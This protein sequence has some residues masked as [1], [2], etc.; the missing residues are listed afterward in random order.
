MCFETGC[1]LGDLEEIGIRVE[2]TRVWRDPDYP[3][4]QH[5]NVKDV[6]HDLARGAW[7]R[8]GAAYMR[9]RP[10][11]SPFLNGEPWALETFG[12]PPGWTA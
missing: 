8:L 9:Q 3:V 4:I 11:P 10:D 1:D 2:P 5:C 7:A 6:L 12:P